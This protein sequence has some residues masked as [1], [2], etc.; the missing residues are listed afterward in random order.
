MWSNRF[1]WVT[2]HIR[3]GR[4]IRIVILSEWRYA[5][6]TW[7]SSFYTNVGQLFLILQS[8]WTEYQYYKTIYSYILS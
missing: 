1:D 5:T 3:Q 7:L 4:E 2:S 8:E 6:N